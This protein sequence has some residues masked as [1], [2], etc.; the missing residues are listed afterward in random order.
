MPLPQSLLNK[1][2]ISNKYTINRLTLLIAGAPHSPFVILRH[3]GRRSGKP[4]ATPI[5]ARKTVDGF[6][7]ALTYGPRVDWLRNVRAGGA[8]GV[9]WGGREYPLR[10]SLDISAPEGLAAFPWFVGTMLKVMDVKDFVR[11]S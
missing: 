1:I 10:G 6:V 9:R 4:Y 7:V 11:L 8:A 3:T 5:I 2:R